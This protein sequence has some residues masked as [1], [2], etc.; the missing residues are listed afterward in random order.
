MTFNINEGV[1]DFRRTHKA[2]IVCLC[3]GVSDREVRSACRKGASNLKKIE[4]ACG[5]GGGCGG[6]HRQLHDIL[7]ETTT[8]RASRAKVVRAALP[9]LV[10]GG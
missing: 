1:A 7:D 3:E 10:L 2:M 8:E 6:C 9:L 4:R 5:A